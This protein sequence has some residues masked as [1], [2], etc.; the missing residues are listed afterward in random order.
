M[1]EFVLAYNDDCP[2]P[3]LAMVDF[4]D[5]GEDCPPSV[6]NKWTP[7]RHPNMLLRAV[8]REVESWILADRRGIANFLSVPLTSVPLF[9]EEEGDPKRKVID[10]ARNSS[11][12]Q[13]REGFVP[14]P[15]S[16][17]AVGSGYN[18]LMERFIRCEWSPAAARTAAPS[19]D[20]C[21]TRL[22]ELAGRLG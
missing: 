19:L 10:L 2:V 18:P 5:T 1:K 22:A 17:A 11:S 12:S 8:V 14:K 16:T 9:P 6:V 13:I 4:M 3:V 7:N 21:M 20:K 15:G